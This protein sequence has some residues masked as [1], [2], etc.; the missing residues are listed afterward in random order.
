MNFKRLL[1]FIAIAFLVF[2]VISRPT[3]AADSV[4]SIGNILRDAGNS[5]STFFD[6][7]L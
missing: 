4:Q 2:F 7:L 1:G 3:S 5:I 6:D